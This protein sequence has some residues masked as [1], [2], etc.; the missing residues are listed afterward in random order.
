[1]TET[2]TAYLRA[3]PD[4]ALLGLGIL[5]AVLVVAMVIKVAHDVL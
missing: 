5:F 2:Y 1:M 3:H 4:K